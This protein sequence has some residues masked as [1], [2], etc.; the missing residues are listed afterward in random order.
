MLANEGLKRRRR[1]VEITFA[2]T[3][4]GWIILSFANAFAA[5]QVLVDLDSII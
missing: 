1:R 4:S 3:L 2:L 5:K